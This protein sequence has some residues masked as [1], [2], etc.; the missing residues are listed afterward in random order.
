MGCHPTRCGEFDGSPDVTP[1][2]YME[3]LLSMAKENR[4][5]VV[6]I[7]EC[8]LGE[9]CACMHV[10]ARMCV[11]RLIPTPGFYCLPLFILKAWGDMPGNKA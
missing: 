5:K 3:Q 7:G 10:L 4:G 1:E 8:G 11:H 2:Q 9:L 6:A